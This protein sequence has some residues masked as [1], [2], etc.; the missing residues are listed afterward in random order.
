MSSV[1][2]KAD[3]LNISLSISAFR[4]IAMYAS[5]IRNDYRMF[6][7]CMRHVFLDLGISPVKN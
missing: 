7:I 5:V 2:K 1:L 3:K 4:W 6:I